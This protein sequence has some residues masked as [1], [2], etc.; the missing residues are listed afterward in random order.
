MLLALVTGKVTSVMEEVSDDINISRYMLVLRGKFNTTN[1]LDPKETVFLVFESRS[2]GLW[3]LFICD[4]RYLGIQLQLVGVSCFVYMQYISKYEFEP[5]GRK[6]T[7]AKR[8]NF[9]LD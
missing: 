1:V 4:S 2:L 9:N 6:Q 8:N 7:V 3:I 5:D